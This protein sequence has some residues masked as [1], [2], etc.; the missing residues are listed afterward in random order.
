M[1]AIAICMI[2]LTGLYQTLGSAVSPA[3]Y[4]VPCVRF[5][6]FVRLFCLLS[7]CN[8]RYEWLVRPYSAGTCTLQE[9]PS[10]AWRTNATLQAPPIAE[11][12][13]ERRLLAVACN[14]P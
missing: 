13:Y 2:A 3:V 9:A 11:A 5:T 7:R 8:T 4:V 10:C 1:K 6:W 12:R 14:S